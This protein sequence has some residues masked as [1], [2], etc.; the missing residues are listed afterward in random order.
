MERRNS[1]IMSGSIRTQARA[2][3]QTLVLYPEG[4]Y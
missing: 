3:N 1:E 4:L 2:T